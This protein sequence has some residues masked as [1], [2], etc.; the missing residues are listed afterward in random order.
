MIYCVGVVG[1]ADG[2]GVTGDA[3]RLLPSLTLPTVRLLP[4]MLRLTSLAGLL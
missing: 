3:T 4:V 2:E 1:D